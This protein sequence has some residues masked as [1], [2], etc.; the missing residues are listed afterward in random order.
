[1]PCLGSALRKPSQAVGA[2]FMTHISSEEALCRPKG[3]T[4]HSIWP[5]CDRKLVFYLFEARTR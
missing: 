5:C 1:M 2:Q 3:T 4:F